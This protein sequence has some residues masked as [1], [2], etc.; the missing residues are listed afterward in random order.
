[1]IDNNEPQS[2]QIN[3]YSISGSRVGSIN[4]GMIQ[5]EKTQIDVSEYF[6]INEGML[7]FEVIGKSNK[8]TL[9][10]IS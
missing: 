9:K 6:G 10:A 7:L 5:K 1:M 4:T 2:F 3:I 8:L